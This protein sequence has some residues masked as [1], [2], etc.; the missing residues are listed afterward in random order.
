MGVVAFDAGHTHFRKAGVHGIG[1]SLFPVAF[2]A[3]VISGCRE[4]GW[5]GRGMGLVAGEAVANRGR[6]VDKRSCKEICVA[7]EAELTFRAHQA[8]ARV[9]VLRVAIGTPLFGVRKMHHRC[10]SLP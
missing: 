10:L 3:D 2:A 7:N 9:L 4:Q 6:S 1:D 5:I 8:V